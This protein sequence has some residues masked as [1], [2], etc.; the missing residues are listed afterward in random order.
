MYA[1]YILKQLNKSRIIEIATELGVDTFGTKHELATRVGKSLARRHGEDGQPQGSAVA[2][3]QVLELLNWDE[4]AALLRNEGPWWG[5]QARYEVTDTIEGMTREA[6][7]ELFGELSGAWHGTDQIDEIC[8]DR[9][10]K[11]KDVFE[12]MSFDEEDSDEEDSD[13]EDSD[14]EDSDEEDSD[15]EDS[16]E[17][18]SDEEDS[19]EDDSYEEDSDEEPT[20]QSMLNYRVGPGESLPEGLTLSEHQLFEHQQLSLDALEKWWGSEERRGVLCLPTG[21]GKTRTAVEFVLTRA[22]EG[23]NRVL[24]LAHRHELVNQA[25]ATFLTRGH[26]RGTS[27]TVARFEAGPKKYG[28]SADVVIASLPTLGWTRELPNVDK[29]LDIHEKFDLIV[30]DECHHAVASTWKRLLKELRR[31]LP[32]S[33]LLGL[34][35]TPTRTAEREVPELWKL[36]GRIIHEVSPLPLIKQGV[37]ARPHIIS[38]ETEQVFEATEKEAQLFQQFDDLPEMLVK[39]IASNKVRNELIVRNL[40]Q[41]RARWGQTLLFAANL[42][43]ADELKRMLRKKGVEASFLHGGS[44]IEERVQILEDFA[45]RRLQVLINVALFNEGTD[46]PA[47]Q[48]VFLA[49][50]TMSRILFQQMVGRGLRGPRLGGTATCYIVGFHD[51]LTNLLQDQLTA[52][53]S[54]EQD[55]LEA[56]GLNAHEAED[57]AQAA[58]TSAIQIQEKSPVAPEDYARR[59]E[60]LLRNVQAMRLKGQWAPEEVPLL[61]WWETSSLEGSQYLPVFHGDKEALG[62]R[63]GRLLQLVQS[64]RPLPE[65]GWAFIQHIP[66]EISQAFARAV[67]QNRGALRYIDLSRSHAAETQQALE[68]MLQR[69]NISEGK[70]AASQESSRPPLEFWLSHAAQNGSVNDT[71]LVRMGSTLQ[72]VSSAHYERVNKVWSDH[73]DLLGPNPEPRAINLFVRM[74]SRF[75]AVAGVPALLCEQLLTEAAQRGDLPAPLPS[76][77]QGPTLG[78]VRQQLSTMTDSQ[79]RES[80]DLLYKAYFAGKYATREEFLMGLIAG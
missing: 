8:Q 38:V 76:H 63:L 66:E 43:H 22:L 39:R 2:R 72:A 7:Q 28:R 56:L 54:T 24:W 25:I 55:A 40:V 61:G 68:A 65:E 36:F 1:S 5:E 13:E 41:E 37:L 57:L 78:E 77:E 30:V 31:R 33:K 9:R 53:F 79:R 45:Y 26:R 34:S 75:P 4:L 59:L 19:D 73:R 27:F 15:E 10:W 6:L 50:P 47:V 64:D 67:L 46:I 32:A 42:E 52:R 35:A 60:E 74:A 69:G 58:I 48:T 17:E 3:H 62:A 71:L 20:W 11:G 49:R 70:P 14:E 21:G 23:G 16:D 18:D 29:L 44:S 12:A 51:K 80:L